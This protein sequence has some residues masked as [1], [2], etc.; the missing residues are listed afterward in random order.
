[1]DVV[2][3]VPCQKFA[4][5]VESMRLYLDYSYDFDLGETKKV[6]K[7]FFDEKIIYFICVAIE[8]FMNM[9]AEIF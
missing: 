9:N 4:Y 5:F 7:I 6:L 2:L 3:W 1:L 8:S